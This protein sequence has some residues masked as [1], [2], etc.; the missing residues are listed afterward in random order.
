M[1]ENYNYFFQYLKKKRINID[2]DEIEFQI[3]SHPDYPAIG[4]I[5]DILSFFNINGLMRLAS[6]EIELLPV[7][8]IDFLKQENNTSKL[9]P[10]GIKK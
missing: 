5:A 4:F 6:S 9:F 7:R 2:S 3:Q 10:A 8:F 1:P